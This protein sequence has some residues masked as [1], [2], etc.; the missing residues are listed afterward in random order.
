MKAGEI[1]WQHA[2]GFLGPLHSTN[3]NRHVDDPD[4]NDF[5]RVR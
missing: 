4:N 2:P 3:G 5:N 1:T